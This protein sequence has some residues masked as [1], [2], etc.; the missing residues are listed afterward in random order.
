MMEQMRC[1]KCQTMF[2]RNDAPPSQ[3]QKASYYCKSC[4]KAIRKA[5]Y[6]KNV[7]LKR[8]YARENQR[9]TR[10]ARVYGI[11]EAEYANLFDA[12]EGKCAICEV[13]ADRLVIDHDHATGN[14]RALL[15]DTCNRGIGLLKDNPEVLQKAADYLRKFS[16]TE[17]SV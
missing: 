12:Q 9:R 5:D 15:C 17:L 11:T 10:L 6:W 8:K 13:V 14:V 16:E 4:L 1:Y 3:R 7:D 2:D